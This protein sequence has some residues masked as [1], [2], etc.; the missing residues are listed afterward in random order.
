M[1]LSANSRS[2]TS[3]QRQKITRPPSSVTRGRILNRLSANDIKANF[4]KSGEICDKAS[5]TPY[6]N[7]PKVGPATDN[8]SSLKYGI[9][10]SI[11]I[12]APSGERNIRF[13]FILSNFA[14][15]ICPI[16]CIKTARASDKKCLPSSKAIAPKYSNVDMEISILNIVNPKAFLIFYVQKNKKSTCFHKCF[17]GG[18]FRTRT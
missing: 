18:P 6:P 8:I 15:K 1:N 16:S 14:H 2:N 11:S 12:L 17:S 13:I 10:S 9:L 3:A 5:P 4:E 7:I